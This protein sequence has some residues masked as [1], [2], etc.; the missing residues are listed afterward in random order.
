M[1]REIE[2]FSL[3]KYLSGCLVTWVEFDVRA[4]GVG[5]TP[6]DKKW[7]EEMVRK[8]WSTVIIVLFLCVATEGQTWSWG[9]KAKIFPEQYP[10]SIGFPDVAP[11]AGYFMNYSHQIPDDYQYR[12][13]WVTPRPNS[14]R[15]WHSVS[16]E[17]R[18]VDNA[19]RMAEAEAQGQMLR[20]RIHDLVNQLLTNAADD[21]SDGPIVTVST[22]VNLN[23]LYVVSS[24]GRFLGEQTISELQQAGVRVVDVRKTP[25]IL[26][27]E[28]HG[29]YGL[30][31]DMDQLEYAHGV[32]FIVAG[33]YT[34][35]QN[36]IFVNARLL[37]NDDAMVVSSA[38]STFGIDSMVGQLLRDEGLFVP[39]PEAPV[40]LRA[41][42]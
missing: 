34:Y 25:S 17:G 8:I 36:Q 21:F 23:S 20:Q 14:T 27:R 26:I 28:K 32:E 12:T 1:S 2:Q 39:L 31:R 42:K 9:N 30:S 38:S 29:E 13:W 6:A 16:D 4:V 40:Q 41:F 24:L 19:K 22:F 5:E 7:G 33:T 35:S 15:W 3:S 10:V 37:R 11:N 18:H